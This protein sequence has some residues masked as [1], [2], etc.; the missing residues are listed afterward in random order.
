MNGLR[1]GQ[2]THYFDRI[3]V[4][5]MQLEGPLAVGDYIQF[6][7]RDYVLFDQNV[8]SMQVDHQSISNAQAGD[9]VAIRVHE[10]V[11]EGTL[12]FKI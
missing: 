11:R 3:H 2:V 8:T 10:K 6:V 12:V 7:K 1:V 9:E 4:A 5:V